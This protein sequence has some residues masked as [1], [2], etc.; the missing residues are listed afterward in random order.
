MVS[1]EQ[2]DVEAQVRAEADEAKAT[3]DVARDF[4]IDNDE[5]LE[6]ANDIL[7]DVKTKLK[8]LDLS[9]RKITDPLNQALKAARELFRPAEQHYASIEFELKKSIGKYHALLAERKREAIALLQAPT[10]PAPAAEEA[11]ATLRQEAPASSGVTV[12]T[13][14]DFVVE[15]PD[16]VPR[17]YCSVDMGTIRKGV[18]DG[19]R[20][21]PGVRIFE[22]QRVAARSK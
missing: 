18:A 14:W 2:K 19:V 22:N 8:Q 12:T 9:K 1:R 7:R 5:D 6:F 13:F 10:T 16:M 21:I 20:D 17:E 15:R 11:L 3:L 4:S